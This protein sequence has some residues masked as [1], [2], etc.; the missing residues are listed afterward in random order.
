[1]DG[2][3]KNISKGNLSVVISEL[4][5][6]KT[7]TTKQNKLIRCTD[8]SPA[9]WTAIEE[10]ESDE[11]EEDSEDEKRLHS[12]KKAGIGQDPREEA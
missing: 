10:Y 2:A 5:S 8:K 1:V 12:A 7:L 4:E 9:C 3:I 11:V 6:V